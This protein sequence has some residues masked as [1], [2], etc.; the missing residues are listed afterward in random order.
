MPLSLPVDFF[1]PLS[2]YCLFTLVLASW[3]NS[4]LVHDVLR[5]SALSLSL[6]SV[7]YFHVA[8]MKAFMTKTLM[9]TLII[10]ESEWSLFLLLCD[11]YFNDLFFAPLLLFLLFS[12]NL[13]GA[14]GSSSPGIAVFS[15]WLWWRRS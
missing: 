6:L 8:A 3:K 5:D 13:I 1:L 4:L 10:N 12:V 7:L 2:S 11:V 14:D 15:S 9:S